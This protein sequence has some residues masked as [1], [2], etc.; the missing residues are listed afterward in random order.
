M[1]FAGHRAAGT[2]PSASYRLGVRSAPLHT[3]YSPPITEA[4]RQALRRF[5]RQMSGFA[6]SRDGL[7]YG[8]ETRTSSPVDGWA[9]SDQSSDIT[10]VITSVIAPV[11]RH[12]I[13]NQ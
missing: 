10:S 6:S 3:L 5:E 1:L 12:H 7:L 13:S 8:A 9:F 11:I 2:L 4:L